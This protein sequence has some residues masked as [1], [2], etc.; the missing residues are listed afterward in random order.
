[1][2][3]KELALKELAFDLHRYQKY[4]SHPY[5]YHLTK[6]EEVLHRFNHTDPTLIIAAWFHDSMEDQGATKESLLK[7]GVPAETVD[8]VYRVSDEPGA[9]RKER[10]A[11]TYPKINGNINATIVKLADRIANVEEGVLTGN[12]KKF[13]MYQSEYKEFKEKLFSRNPLTD[14]MWSHLDQLLPHTKAPNCIDF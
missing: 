6:V 7:L 12:S 14:A 5:S 8:I 3:L 11:N 4:G 1:M 13:S 9:N 2:N 10:K